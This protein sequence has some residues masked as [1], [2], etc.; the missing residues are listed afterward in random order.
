MPNQE[1]FYY[2]IAIG[3]FFI[4]YIVQYYRGKSNN[5][6]IAKTWAS[7][8]LSLFKKNFANASEAVIYKDGNSDFKYFLS[9]RV[10]CQGYYCQMDLKRRHDLFYVLYDLFFGTGPDT[11]TIDIPL[12]KMEPFIFAV[13]ST[14]YKE[15]HLDINTYVTNKMEHLELRPSV[16]WTDSPELATYLL[17]D[18]V[19]KALKSRD[20]ISFHFSD[21]SEFYSDKCLRFVFQIPSDLEKLKPL[22]ETT[23]LMIDLVQ[24]V[25]L[26][27]KSRNELMREK[28]RVSGTQKK[29]R[30]K[31]LEES[32]KRKK[33]KED[34]KKKK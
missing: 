27:D 22:M 5:D 28:V 15:E 24:S 17:N 6:K 13:A 16:I 33:E 14:K 1:H 30:E 12:E 20:F 26:K 2:E 8:Y 31:E 21:Q 9:G 11:L 29:N 25:E 32:R 23:I 19:V 34:Q 4:A 10:N 18:D 3:F 7:L